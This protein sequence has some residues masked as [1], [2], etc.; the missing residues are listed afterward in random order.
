MAF[1]ITKLAT[2]R[3]KESD[4]VWIDYPG[5]LRLKIARMGNDNFQ[6]A[7]LKRRKEIQR[8]ARFSGEDEISALKETST[9]IAA[10][11]LLKDW[12]GMIEDGTP[13]PY[14]VEN[15]VRLMTKYPEF[16]RL[17]EEAAADFENFKSDEEAA[18]R[19]NSNSS[20]AGS[21]SGADTSEA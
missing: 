13:V 3:N 10:E 7:T 20:P 4:G 12:E 14:S 19:G 6:R 18:V 5:G 15:A 17:V 16:L 11:H 21:S 2:D 9:E 1:D 8:Q